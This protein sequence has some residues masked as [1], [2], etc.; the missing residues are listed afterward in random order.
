M[1]SVL[2]AGLSACD[3]AGSRAVRDAVRQGLPNHD[4]VELPPAWVGKSQIGAARRS[5]GIVLA[6]AALTPA[7][8]VAAVLASLAACPLA[9]LGVGAPPLAG[10][11]R[12][13]LV[14]RTVARS[15]LMLLADEQSAHHLA[16]AGAPTPMRVSAD[17]AWMALGLMSARAVRDD[18]VAVILDGRVGPAV[19]HNL[20]DAL[21]TVTGAGRRVRLVPWAGA[22]SLDAAM[23]HRLATALGAGAA[24]EPAPASLP[25]AASLVADAHAVVALRHRGVHPAAAAGVPVI[26]VGVDTRIFAL[27]GRLGQTAVDPQDMSTTL[28][29]ALEQVDRHG[30]PSPAT[31]REEMLRAEAGLRLLRL[32]L[33]PDAVGADEVDH[34]PLVPVPWL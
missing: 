24:V 21:A 3:R 8:V 14:R 18:S 34:L 19:E 20:A 12:S 4:V 16:A 32:I 27:A 1:P 5:D 29:I 2:L 23:A 13:A 26:G 15:D 17:P 10:R 31:V 33:E 7:T 30:P 28:P 22:D 25:E 6:G 9:L 11:V